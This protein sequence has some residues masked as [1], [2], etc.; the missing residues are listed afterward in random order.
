MSGAPKAVFLSYASQDADAAK[1]IAEALR[2]AGIEVWFDQN[3]LV[4]GDAWDAKIRK[5]IAECALFV[6]IISVNTQARREGYFRLEW[7]IAAQRTHMM[8]EQVAFLLPLVVDETRDAAADVPAEFR[9]VQWTRLCQGYG[10]QALNE[11]VLAAL[12][13]RVRNLLQGAAVVEANQPG[14]V[15]PAAPASR[16]SRWVGYSWAVVG[17]GIGLFYALRPMWLGPRSKRESPPVVAVSTEAQLLLRQAKALIDEEPLMT[18]ETLRTA[19]ELCEKAAALSPRD[20]DIWATL[21]RANAELAGQY[22]EGGDA[23]IA[24]SRS[25]AERALQLAPN[26]IEAGLA[27]A[28]VELDFLQVDPG[29]VRKRLEALLRRAPDD[30]RI[31][32]LLVRTEPPNAV[33]DSAFRWL[34][35]AEALSGGK[36]R[37]A[38][39]QAWIYWGANRL[40]ESLAAVERSL[41]AQPLTEAY[42]LKLMLLRLTSGTESALIWLKQIPPVV[43]REDRPAVIAYETFYFGRKPEEALRV[44][45]AVPREVFEEGRYFEVR[46]LLAGEALLM[47]GKRRAAE[48]ELRAALKVIDERLASNPR[49]GRLWHAKGRAQFHLSDRAGAES[50]FATASELGLRTIDLATQAQLLGRT[51]EVLGLIDQTLDRNVTRWPWGLHYFKHNPLY[52]SLQ[53]DQ[54]FRQLI[55]RAEAWLAADLNL[56][57]A[58]PTGAA[59]EAVGMADNKSV[60]VLAFTNLSDDKANEYFSDGISEELLNV[61]AKVPGLKVSAR[62]S[63]FHFKGKD[64]PIPEIARKLG[65]A[66]VVEGSVRRAGDKVRITAQL[67]KAADGFHVWSDTFTRDIKD[68]FAVQDEIAGLIA[69]NLSLRLGTD[70]P[71]SGRA[72]VPGAFELYVRGR[73][74]WNLR[75]REGYAQAENLLKRAIELDP[76]FARAH[77]ALADVWMIASYED[78]IGGGTYGWRNSPTVAKIAAKA[79]QA[80]ALDPVCAESHTSLASALEFGWQWDAA[81]RAYRRAIELNPNYATARHW[82]GMLL[83]TQGKIDEALRQLKQAAE[84]DPLSHR[85]LDTYASMLNKTGRPAEALAVAEQALAQQPLAIQAATQKARAMVLLGRANEAVALLEKAV[86]PSANI[87]QRTNALHVLHQAGADAA[88]RQLIGAT[89]VL[90]SSQFKVA[91][92]IALG[93]PGEALAELRPADLHQSQLS[94]LA[95]LSFYD[96]IRE[97]P[98]FLQAISEVGYMEHYRRARAWLAANPPKGKQ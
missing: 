45:Q 59:G 29:E 69:K 48:V 30:H 82:F 28:T 36:A 5:Q 96:P 88:V 56:V 90:P 6:P 50:S 24:A 72:T 64:T 63:A 68:V 32:L 37:A 84:S 62:T 86:T 58:K 81:E 92:L 75:T 10:G 73:A 41:T 34:A 39:R 17:I 95:L 42:H 97:D 94:N 52:D 67:I 49:H 57:E 98:R 26:S 89:E 12:C 15:A 2:A 18:R 16:K 55:A 19:S 33:T 91:S 76:G 77:S 46:A 66:Y 7:R 93:R 4:G 22:H 31:L 87:D 83:L 43:L 79:E 38:M 51:E 40:R 13:T 78:D 1:R 14:T 85:I 35:Q 54:R 47:A 61:L 70:R 3:E 21:A 53:S 71:A 20:A 9:S 65:V 27:M 60:A 23:R 25:Q 44:L 11:T 8:S 80:L 74:A